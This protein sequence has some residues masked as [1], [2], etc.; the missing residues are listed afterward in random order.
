MNIY[1]R[2]LMNQYATIMEDEEIIW[3]D[4]DWHPHESI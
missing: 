4:N 1:Q 2:I 3:D